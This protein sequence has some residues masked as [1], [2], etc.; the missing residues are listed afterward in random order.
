ML[1]T[2]HNEKVLSFRAWYDLKDKQIKVL[3]SSIIVKFYC[4]SQVTSFESSFEGLWHLFFFK[5][6]KKICHWKLGKSDSWTWYYQIFLELSFRW[7][8][9]VLLY[10]LLW[11]Q[12]IKVFN[13]LDRFINLFPFGK[14]VKSL[15]TVWN[16]DDNQMKYLSL[17]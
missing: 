17:K 2:V 3:L 16:K 11:C 8:K 13:R 7:K 14:Y 12:R 6:W 15:C 5:F 10:H 9:A 4:K 1:T